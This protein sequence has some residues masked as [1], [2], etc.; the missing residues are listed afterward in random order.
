MVGDDEGDEDVLTRGSTV[1][2]TYLTAETFGLH[3]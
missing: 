1:R 3:W 2:K